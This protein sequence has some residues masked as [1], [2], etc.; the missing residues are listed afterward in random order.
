MK[1]DIK[2]IAVTAVFCALAYICMFVFRFKVGFLTFD[3]KDAVIAVISFLFGPI[4]GVAT[5][6]IVSLFELVTVSD[7]GIYGLIMNFC[8]SASF[9][10]A[11]GII[12][13]Y[14][15]TFSGAIYA[16]AASVIVVTL[17]MMLANVLVTPFYMGVKTETVI[18]MIPTLLLP[19]NLCKATMNA[20]VTL[21]IYKP[22]TS[23]LKSLGLVTSAA[24]EKFRFTKKTIVLTISALIV[25]VITAF[26]LIYSLGGSFE[27]VK[28]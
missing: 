9:A 26:V 20:A 14:K 28:S 6:G 21:I 23:G 2:K 8:S 18:N 25:A 7:T 19:F 3:F 1:N 4:Y 27:L 5:V 13:K 17:V 16:A 15:K 10:F 12:Y 24:K 22:L 11:C